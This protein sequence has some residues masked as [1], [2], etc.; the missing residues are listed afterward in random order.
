MINEELSKEAMGYAKNRIAKKAIRFAWSGATKPTVKLFI[1]TLRIV[2]GFP[3]K[4]IRYKIH[5]EHGEMSVKQLIRKDQGAQSVDIDELGLGD[6]KKIANKY[7]LDFAIV[8]STELD[9]PKYTVFF[10]ARDAD[11][12]TAVVNE[13][14]AR[15]LRIQKEGRSSILAKLRKFKEIVAS[16]PKKVAEKRKDR[17]L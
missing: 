1:K 10:K 15:K 8:K 11:A 13:Y 16:L 5:P 4:A 17:E 12:I 14:T 2:G 7:G 6:F 9:P 3:V